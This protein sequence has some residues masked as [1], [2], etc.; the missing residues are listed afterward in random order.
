MPCAIPNNRKRNWKSM[1]KNRNFRRIVA[2]NRNIL[3]RIDKVVNMNS[4][5]KKHHNYILIIVVI[6]KFICTNKN[7]S[8][9]L[10][11]FF[12]ILL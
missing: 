7:S 4:V 3:Q 11:P 1:N 6:F 9:F 10:K 2:L 5:L 12:V 8:K